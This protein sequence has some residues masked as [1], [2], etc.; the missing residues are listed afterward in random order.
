MTIYRSYITKTLEVYLE[1][2]DK[3][4][5]GNWVESDPNGYAWKIADHM[6]MGDWLISDTSIDTE[7]FEGEL[8]EF[9]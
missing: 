9:S 8:P 1:F 5:R 4:L 2:D 6:S 3:E 7:E